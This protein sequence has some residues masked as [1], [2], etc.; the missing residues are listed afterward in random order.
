VP[1]K[2]YFYRAFLDFFTPL[3]GPDI[4]VLVLPEP[5]VRV[6]VDFVIR[7]GPL[8]VVVRVLPVNE[9][10]FQKPDA[11]AIFNPVN[12]L[13]FVFYFDYTF[14]PYFLLGSRGRCGGIT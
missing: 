8:D 11:F 6:D 7:P 9:S 14:L 1:N 2:L 3:I 4:T 10:D 13:F 12:Y 5:V